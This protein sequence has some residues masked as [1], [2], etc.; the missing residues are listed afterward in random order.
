MSAAAL[1]V[2]DRH[3][4]AARRSGNRRRAFAVLAVL[5][6][7]VLSL[8]ASGKDEKSP[9]PAKFQISGDGF[10]GDL[11]LKHTVRLLESPKPKS[12]FF[13]ANFVEDTA[14][15][16]ISK[17]RDEG[18]LRPVIIVTI[19]SDDEKKL[20]YVWNET[21]EEP[22]PRSLRARNVHFKIKRGVLYHYALIEFH[23]L[24][25]I[26]GKRAQAYFIETSGLFPLKQNRVFSPNRLKRSVGSLE[27]ALD[28][29]G[30]QEAKVKAEQLSRDDRTGAIRVKIEVTEG[31]KL[32]VRSVR[33]EIY[34]DGTIPPREMRTNYLVEP[35]SKLWEQDFIQSIKTNYYRQGYPNTSVELQTL[36][37]EPA[38]AVAF[39]DLVARVRTGER[40]RIGDVEFQG[41]MSTKDSLLAKR[42]PLKEGDELN[43]IKAERGRYRLSRLGIFDSVDLSYDPVNTNLWNVNYTVKE[44]K[45]IDVSPL[46]G[47]GS[48]DL[49]RG[50]VEINQYNL[51]GLAHNSRLRLIQSFKSSSGDYTYT[52]PELLGDDV[53]IFATGSGLRR[54]EIS[55]TRVEYGGGAGIR[56][57][58]HPIDTDASLRYNYGILQATKT[59][60]N[61]AEEGPQSP[62]V[63]EFIA[64]IRHDRRDNPLYPHKGYQLLANIELAS[65]YLGGDVDF[66]R[67]ELSASYHLP[68]NDSEW[69][70]LGLHHGVA[71]GSTQNLPFTRRFFPGGENSVRGY[72]QG[73]AAP[74]NEEG[75]IV[76]AETYIS[77]NFEFEQA[78]TPKWSVVGF[79]DSVGFA[80]RLG[81]YPGNEALYSVGGGLRWKTLI[82]PVRLEYGYNLNPRPK[83]PSG[84]LQFSLGFPF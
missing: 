19:T 32:I 36:K 10:F 33:Q 35:Y 52:I 75:K 11:K 61:F 69:I 24:N 56:K 38:D 18:Y 63:G 84:T 25:A 54:E 59:K 46:I 57:L 28:R 4:L 74:R 68:L 21:T 55:F 17:L 20:K 60:G 72:Q 16:L 14:M 22:L 53:D 7:A 34:F 73:E 45:T 12:Q 27:D 5:L 65:R 48:Y 42:V 26:S 64:D 58:F 83:D 37:R 31:Q 77:G 29:L 2:D 8:G 1:I 13:D 44:G 41:N 40:V 62:T 80:R 71:G 78:I 51:W 49:L 76:G 79:V 3:T 9:P 6:M 39:L 70:H 30:F 66:Q 23:G 67:I 43:R 81:D 50:G 47:F 82:G 15:I